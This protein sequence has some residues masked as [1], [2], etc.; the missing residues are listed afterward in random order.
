MNWCLFFAGGGWSHHRHHV[1]LPSWPISL[2]YSR[3][4]RSSSG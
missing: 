3:R 4:P 2:I 1:P